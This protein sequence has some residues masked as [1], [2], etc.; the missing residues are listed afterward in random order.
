MV[1]EKVKIIPEV[2]AVILDFQGIINFLD[3]D[4]LF[5]FCIQNREARIERTK[6]GHLMIMLPIGG[7]GGSRE[8]SLSGMFYI[9]NKNKK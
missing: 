9:W 8:L 4:I 6:E 5:D 2:E 3:D 7:E 1:K